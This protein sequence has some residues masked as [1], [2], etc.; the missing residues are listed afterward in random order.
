[1]NVACPADPDA[2]G[3]PIISDVC[4]GEGVRTCRTFERSSGGTKWLR[5]SCCDPTPVYNQE[6][7]EYVYNSCPGWNSGYDADSVDDQNTFDPSIRS[8][9]TG[10]ISFG[11]CGTAPYYGCASG[12]VFCKHNSKDYYCHDVINGSTYYS[13]DS[14][15]VVDANSVSCTA[16]SDDFTCCPVSRTETC[17]GDYPVTD[18][19]LSSHQHALK[20]GSQKS[21]R[22]CRYGCIKGDCHGCRDNSDCVVGGMQGNCETASTGFRSCRFLGL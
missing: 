20:C 6:T 16:A 11:S 22:A 1:M 4:E 19:Y 5:W 18:Y 17:D 14:Y 21:A 10:N 7:Q 8:C 12:V 15:G 9:A 3:N 2:D 13:P